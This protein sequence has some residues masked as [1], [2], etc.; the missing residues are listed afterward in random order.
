VS[1]APSS[2]SQVHPIVRIDFLTRVVTFPGFMLVVMV[3][4][5]PSGMPTGMVAA[6]VLHGLAWPHVAYWIAR[7]STH[8]KAAEL[9]NLMLDALLIGAWLPPM[10]FSVWPTTA[11]MVGLLSGMLSVGGPAHA[12]R[13]V[14]LLAIG[15]LLSGAAVGFRIQP[16]ASL[17]VALLSSATLFGYA[18]TFAYLSHVQSKRVVHAMRQIRQQNADIVEKSLLLQQRSAELQ[19]AKEAAESAN[20]TK[21]QFLANMSHELRTPLN[22][23]IGYSEMLAEEAADLQREDFVRDLERIRASGKHLLSIINEVLDLSKIEAGRMDLFIETFELR[24]LLEGVL[25]SV[26]PLVDAGRNRLELQLAGDPGT[27]HT[28]QTKLRQI[29]LNLL[30]NACKFT[31]NGTVTVQLSHGEGAE[32]FE[33]AVR[34]TGIGMTPEQLE[35]LFQPFTQ[36]DASTTRRYGGTGLGLAVSRRFAQMMGGDITVASR[37]GEGSTFTLRLP[38]DV[39]PQPRAGAPEPAAATA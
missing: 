5:Y 14:V 39:R 9:R 36:A 10:H 15:T 37:A 2:Q 30:S 17:P 23:I 35:R 11:I 18:L 8:S 27:L 26:A 22:G 28:D 3:H 38:R 13:G 21:S 4:L 24:P 31:A 7:N 16:E 29:L 20:R 32:A 25:A 33:V 34:D 12:V 19:E 6:L 1:P